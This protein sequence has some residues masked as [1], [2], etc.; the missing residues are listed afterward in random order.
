MTERSIDD[1]SSNT[2]KTIT[3]MLYYNDVKIT[4]KGL[5]CT[6][7]ASPRNDQQYYTNLS[8]EQQ[9]QQ[10]LEQQQQIL[11]LKQHCQNHLQ[12]TSEDSELEI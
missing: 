10:I 11:D 9:Q 8:T 3:Q 2:D 5:V 12:I 7:K 6:W 4:G 1:W